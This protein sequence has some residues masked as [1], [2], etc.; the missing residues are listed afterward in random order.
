M[1]SSG[2]RRIH[3]VVVDGGK[4]VATGIATKARASEGERKRLMR[5]ALE[6]YVR[7]A[8]ARGRL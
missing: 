8:A 7:A 2:G 4:N 1:W 3:L 6:R 5:A